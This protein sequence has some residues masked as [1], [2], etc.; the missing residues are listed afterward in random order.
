MIR[1]AKGLP[2]ISVLFDSSSSLNECPAIDINIAT[3]GAVVD[4]V[5]VDDTFEDTAEA[6]VE[7]AVEAIVEAIVEAAVED[8]VG[9]V[10]DAAW[11]PAKSFIIPFPLPRDNR[12]CFRNSA[13]AAAPI[14][15][16]LTGKA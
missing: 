11:Y 2:F 1:A 4:G 14:G 15:N 5:S 3:A 9:E 8:I 16:S 10:V 6:V 13:F 12:D 7:A